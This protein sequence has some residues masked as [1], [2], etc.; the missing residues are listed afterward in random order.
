MK[1]YLIES[2]IVVPDDF[3]EAEHWFETHIY[4]DGGA[5]PVKSTLDA[6]KVT[7][8]HEAWIVEPSADD[9]EAYNDWIGNV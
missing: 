1:F 8:T 3:E 6:D 5:Y 7:I 9:L 4:E 2:L